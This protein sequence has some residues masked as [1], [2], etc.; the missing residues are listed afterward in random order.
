MR[1]SMTKTL[2][3]R[4]YMLRCHNGMYAYRRPH[5]DCHRDENPFRLN[6]SS[7][8]DHLGYDPDVLTVYPWFMTRDRN[9][10]KRYRDENNALR[11]S[12]DIGYTLEI[13]KVEATFRVTP[14]VREFDR[15]KKGKRR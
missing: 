3:Q 4:V 12:G 9:Q 13:V 11:K 7:A 5:V 6:F 1:S 2:R 14:G 8:L 15:P 10:A